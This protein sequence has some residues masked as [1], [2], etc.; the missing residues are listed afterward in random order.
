MCPPPRGLGDGYWE[1]LDNSDVYMSLLSVHTYRALYC[2]LNDMFHNISPDIMRRANQVLSLD[3]HN[4]SILQSLMFFTWK[5]GLPV[6]FYFSII[7]PL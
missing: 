2:L 4:V 1:S 7:Y 6:L 3:I 5:K